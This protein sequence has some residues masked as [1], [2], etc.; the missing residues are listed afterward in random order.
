M[1]DPA[2]HPLAAPLG[3]L[4]RLGLG[5]GAGGLLVAALGLLIAPE[6]VV[7]G[8]LAA[9]AFWIGLSIGGLGLLMIHQLNAGA[10]GLVTQRHLEAMA[11]TV[12]PM[13]VLFLPILL[14]MHALYHWT[15]DDVVAAD[16]VLQHKRPY[17]NVPFFVVRAV[18]Y[19]AFWGTLAVLL[20]RWAREVDETGA[21][22]PV[23]RM[24]TLSAAGLV[25]HVL[26]MT[27]VT[28]DW[29]MS[30]EPHWHSTLYPWLMLASTTLTALA[31]TAVALSRL[32]RRGPLAAVT[33]K[34]HFHDLGNLMLAFVV[35][36]TYMMFAQYLIMWSGNVPHDI[37][38]YV[39]RG[40][41]GWMVVITAVV[42]LHFALP[43]ALLLSRR[44]KRSGR[45]LARIA[46]GLLLVHVL[47]LAWFLL[48]SFEHLS[49]HAF[50]T[51]A[52]AWVGLGGVWLAAYA[53]ALV[54]RPL[55]PRRDPRY[56]D[57]LNQHHAALH[58]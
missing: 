39:P 6:A 47:F 53:W 35:V 21:V 22:R 17:L 7:R 30:L 45:T 8:Y 27:W 29:Y 20:A 40:E 34:K 25:G 46:T 10:W 3:R 50:W 49:V 9:Y 48:P 57:T 4:R 16:A 24:R 52:A 56:A 32:S 18:L 55:L 51:G 5:L 14:G 44:A 1:T 19:F 42:L 15:H 26:L 12:L 2:A 43:F 41:G 58:A 13:A 23:E 54:R 11:L 28:T 36:W 38:W 37:V 33:Q 31:F